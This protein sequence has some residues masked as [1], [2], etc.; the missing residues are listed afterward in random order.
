MLEEC[1]LPYVVRPVNIG[2][3]E[4]FQPDFLKISP[5][6]RMP[7]I[8]DPD[9][10]GGKAISVFESGAIL[11]YLGRRTGK[12]YPADERARLGAPPPELEAAVEGLG[13]RRGEAELRDPREGVGLGLEAGVED[14]TIL[15]SRLR[16]VWGWGRGRRLVRRD[17]LDRLRG[18]RGLVGT[19]GERAH[20]THGELAP[21]LSDEVR[22]ERTGDRFGRPVPG[23][24]ELGASLGHDRAGLEIA[25]LSDD[26]EPA[27]DEGDGRDERRARDRRQ[28]RSCPRDGDHRHS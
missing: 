26:D 28:R 16:V 25:H 4:Q 3:G 14:V 23:D 19:S 27:S 17:G 1:G 9:G 12:F 13:G 6:A 22:E 5:N 10:P 11:Q 20:R 2:R 21:Q 18:L 24:V 15:R 7:A 8:V